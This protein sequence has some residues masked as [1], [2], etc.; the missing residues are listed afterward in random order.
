MYYQL[1]WAN[2]NTVDT[3]DGG[4]YTTL[5]LAK[6]AVPLFLEELIKRRK[7]QYVAV[8]TILAGYIV[9]DFYLKREQKEEVYRAP[10]GGK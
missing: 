10:A 8:D 9:I 5:A 1:K 2:E 6:Q 7:R 3:I 4:T